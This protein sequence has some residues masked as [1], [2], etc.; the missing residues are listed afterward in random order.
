[1][2]K[3]PS[4]RVIQSYNLFGETG[5]MPDL[6]HCETIAA[7]SK[8]H[9]WELAPHRHARL[10]QFLVVEKG[11]GRAVLEGETHKLA[12]SRLVN[13]PVGCVHAFT[14]REG[15]D[16]WVLTLAAEALDEV[17]REGEGLRPMLAQALVLRGSRE[18]STLMR[19]I[20]G[21]YAAL[22]FG[23]AHIL[24]ALCAQLAGLVARRI[25]TAGQGVRDGSEST[26]Q[27]RFESS[28]RHAF[29]CGTGA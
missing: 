8:L 6:V 12:A 5:D 15:T 17:V 3:E 27:R 11:G 1:M 24:R 13:V 28:R 23:R 19:A 21:E 2:R 18:T 4:S 9:N 29:S 10:H 22:R 20:A 25:E 14:F 26:L 7:R 16:G